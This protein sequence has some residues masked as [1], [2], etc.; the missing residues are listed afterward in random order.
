VVV[1]ETYTRP[2]DDADDR[3]TPGPGSER[4]LAAPVHRLVH[5]EDEQP[6]PGTALCLSG[7]GYR[8]MVCCT[9]V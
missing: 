7:G 9:A 1:P 4:P 8:A 3:S 5:E 2:T 6:E